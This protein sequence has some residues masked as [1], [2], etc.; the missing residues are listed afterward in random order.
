VVAE[1]VTAESF[2]GHTCAEPE[3]RAHKA[4]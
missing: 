4:P 3:R 2:A 1:P